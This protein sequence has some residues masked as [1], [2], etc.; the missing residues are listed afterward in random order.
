MNSK[1]RRVLFECTNLVQWRVVCYSSQPCLLPGEVRW[2]K[3]GGGGNG[4][5]ILVFF[6]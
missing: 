2:G 6:R 4:G 5:H 1:L 3:G